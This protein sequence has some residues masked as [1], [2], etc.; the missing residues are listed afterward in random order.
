MIWLRNLLVFLDVVAVAT[1]WFSWMPAIATIRP[2]WSKLFAWSFAAVC[3]FS[4]ALI[5]L[6]GLK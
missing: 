2:F 1:M 5:L 4:I 3:T 6:Q